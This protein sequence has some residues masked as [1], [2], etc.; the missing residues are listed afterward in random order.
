M[1]LNNIQ[2][3]VSLTDRWKSIKRSIK[4]DLV[5]NIC[6]G[7]LFLIFAGCLTYLTFTTDSP[8][9]AKAIQYSLNGLSASFAI[10]GIYKSIKNY[11]NLSNRI[12]DAEGKW[13]A[14]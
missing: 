9:W 3:P 10:F 5:I 11:K 7:V 12:A 8:M 2:K 6:F 4:I 13:I 14:L 1:L